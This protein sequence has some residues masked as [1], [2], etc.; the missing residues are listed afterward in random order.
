M[1]FTLKTLL[2][3]PQKPVAMMVPTW[4]EAPVIDKMLLRAIEVLQ[5]E[6][7]RIYVGVYPN[8]LETMAVV[9]AVADAHSDR[10]T[11]VIL[12]HPGPTTKSDNINSVITYIFADEQRRAQPY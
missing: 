1:P 6:N 10:V 9:K 11:M 7:Y 12:D 8:D 5:Y 4:Q 3:M 2:E